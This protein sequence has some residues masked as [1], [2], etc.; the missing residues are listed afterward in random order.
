MRRFMY[1][2]TLLQRVM[3]FTTI[4]ITEDVRDDLRAEK[5]GGETYDELLQRLLEDNDE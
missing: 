2:Y 4:R 5:I 1:L 3:G